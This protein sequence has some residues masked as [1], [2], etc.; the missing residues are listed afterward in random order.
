M[1]GTASLANRDFGRVLRTK[2]RKVVL[3]G[4]AHHANEAA[5]VGYSAESD[6]ESKGNEIRWRRAVNSNSQA[7]LSAVCKSSNIVSTTLC[8]AQPREVC[9][10]NPPHRELRS[11]T[12]GFTV[13][14]S[15]SPFS[16]DT[17]HAQITPILI[18]T[19]GWDAAGL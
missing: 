18:G 19:V 12:K 11:T 5:D 8:C 6:G 16:E 10:A 14:V 7:T 15:Y 3:S 9:S 13:E 17:T 2:S 4:A 1:D